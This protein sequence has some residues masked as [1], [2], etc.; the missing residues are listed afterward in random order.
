MI[1]RETGPLPTPHNRRPIWFPTSFSPRLRFNLWDLCTGSGWT[2]STGTTD[3][4][5]SIVPAT[6]TTSTVFFPFVSFRKNVTL[7]A[8]DYWAV[9]T[10][11]FLISMLLRRKLFINGNLQIHLHRA[12]PFTRP[13]SVNMK[14]SN[15]QG[16]GGW[17]F[18]CCSCKVESARRMSVLDQSLQVAKR[19]VGV[20]T[21]IL[22]VNSKVNLLQ[23]LH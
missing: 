1:N 6:S 2:S 9:S 21:T 10:I 18:S 16:L 17:R 4:T 22:I 19:R 5:T 12:V 3:S 20:S 13:F 14:I 8:N 23:R 11:S 15:L 7:G